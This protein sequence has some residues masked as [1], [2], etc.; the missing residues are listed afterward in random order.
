MLVEFW[1]FAWIPL[2]S[3]L[4]E[5]RFG[6]DFYKN[7]FQLDDGS[8]ALAFYLIGFFLSFRT[9]AVWIGVASYFFIAEG[10]VPYSSLTWGKNGSYFLIFLSREVEGFYWILPL[11]GSFTFLNLIWSWEISLN[12]F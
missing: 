7:F 12:I 2:V 4:L 11:T 8:G 9:G 10:S 3:L 6:L 5:G 1:D